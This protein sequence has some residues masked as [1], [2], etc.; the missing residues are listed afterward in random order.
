MAENSQNFSSRTLESNA[1][2]SCDNSVKEQVNLLT[3]CF[4]SFVKGE[5]PKVASCAVCDLLGHHN[6]Q[7]PELKR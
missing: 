6:D 2:L 5:A 4:A 7:S 3:K 1:S